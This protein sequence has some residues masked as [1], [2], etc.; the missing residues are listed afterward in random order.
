M[1]TNIVARWP[2]STHDSHVFR[3][4]SICHFFEENHHSLDDGILLGDSGYACQ[5]FMMTPYSNPSTPAEA[6]YNNA[7]CKTRVKI[8]QTFGQWK[9]RFHVLHSEIR[10]APEK[11]CIIIGACAILHIAILLKEPMED[12]R[13]RMKW[14]V[15]KYIM[16]LIKEGLCEITFV[17]PIL[18]RLVPSFHH[19]FFVHLKGHCHDKFA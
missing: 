8:E 19:H 12:E 14:M 15:M 6:A 7:H 18:A 10:M 11:V 5:P 4:S 1:F 13:L 9:R 2:G 17:A 3:S 16:V